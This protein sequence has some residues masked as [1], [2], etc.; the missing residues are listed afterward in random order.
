MHYRNFHLILV[1]CMLFFSTQNVVKGAEPVPYLVRDINTQISAGSEI[2]TYMEA[3]ANSYF[4]SSGGSQAGLWKTDGTPDGTIFLKPLYTDFQQYWDY[5]PLAGVLDGIVFFEACDLAPLNSS[6]GCELWKTDG[7]SAGTVMAADL[8]PGE[9]SSNPRNFNIMGGILFFVTNDGLWGLDA[10]NS[11]PGLVIGVSS[12][13][14]LISFDSRVWI[15]GDRL[16]FTA[17]DTEHGREL[18]VSDGTPAGTKVLFDLIP[19]SGGSYPKPLL[20]Q[21]GRLYFTA[22]DENS[23]F[24]L[25][26]YDQNLGSLTRSSDV[27]AY[28]WDA[29]SEVQLMGNFIFFRSCEHYSVGKNFSLMAKLPDLCLINPRSGS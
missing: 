21:N 11:V 23:G 20:A 8:T 1:I 15:L 13:T 27:N 26:I 3:G 29:L 2:M 7:T 9:K 22:M 28:S 24:E 17:T 5:E 25:W 19:G 18:W 4:I 10:A 6:H 12:Q 16:Y 14:G